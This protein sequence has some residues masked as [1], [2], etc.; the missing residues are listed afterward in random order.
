LDG[1]GGGGDLGE[2]MLDIG[3]LHILS[4]WRRSSLGLRWWRP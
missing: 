3:M 4:P 2:L 1:D